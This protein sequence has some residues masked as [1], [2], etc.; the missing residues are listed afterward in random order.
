MIVKKLMALI[1]PTMSG[2]QKALLIA[3]SKLF[4]R[5]GFSRVSVEELCRQARV[6]KVTFYR[7]Y[8]GKDELILNLLRFLFD[9]MLSTC[10][11]VLDGDLSLKQK[12]DT[13]MILKQDFI[14]LLGAEILEGLFHHPSAREYYLRLSEESFASVRALLYREQQQGGINPRLNVEM[15][16]A[17]LREVAKIFSDNSIA[18]YSTSFPELVTQ[19]NDILIYGIFPRDTQ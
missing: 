9:D 12:L 10:Q 13:V 18:Q 2:K 4:H 8:K 14:S 17:L 11:D 16:L 15:F 1:P 5:Y 3:A 19:V 7:Y 6:S